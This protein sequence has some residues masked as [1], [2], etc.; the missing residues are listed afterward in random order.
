M[1][2]LAPIIS[3]SSLPGIV[4]AAGD[5]A[6]ARLPPTIIASTNSLAFRPEA[7]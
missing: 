5:R 6:S 1:N 2:Q 7:S 4:T 3:S